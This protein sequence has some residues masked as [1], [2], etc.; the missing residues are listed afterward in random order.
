MA[1]RGREIDTRLQRFKESDGR[2]DRGFFFFGSFDNHPRA[3]DASRDDRAV[4]PASEK[5]PGVAVELGHR[6]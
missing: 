2:C 3:G 4:P 5:D 6:R 1:S